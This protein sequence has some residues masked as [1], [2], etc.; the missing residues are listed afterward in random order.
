M[1]TETPSSTP[2]ADRLWY[3]TIGDFF[4]G[5]GALTSVLRIGYWGAI[6]GLLTM[7]IVALFVPDRTY[8]QSPNYLTEVITGAPNATPPAGRRRL[9]AAYPGWG[10]QARSGQPVRGRRRGYTVGALP[11]LGTGAAGARAFVTDALTCPFNAGPTGGGSA[12][13]RWST[14]HGV[15]GAVTRLRDAAAALRDLA[16]SACWSVSPAAA[17]HRD[18][19]PGEKT[20]PLGNAAIG[21][22]MENGIPEANVPARPHLRPGVRAALPEVKL[23]LMGAARAAL[24]GDVDRVDANLEIA[25]IRAVSSVRRVIQAKIPPPL[26]P[27]TVAAR[28]RRNAPKTGRRATAAEQRAFNAAHAAGTAVMADSPTTPL[29]DTGQYLKAITHVVEGT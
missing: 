20:S 25:G 7:M 8:A 22:L 2:R 4:V 26:Q 18:P 15:G 11:A 16:V 17:N 13:C 9:R 29:D 28:S 1:T 19:V 10:R 12:F 3:R 6:V 24:R 23:A 21:Y 27:A 14:R 5:D